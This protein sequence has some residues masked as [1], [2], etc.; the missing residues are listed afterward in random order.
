MGLGLVPA[1]GMADPEGMFRLF[2][3]PAAPPTVVRA[4]FGLLALTAVVLCV[5]AFSVRRLEI[6]YSTE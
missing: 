5:A 2:I 4:V 3:A 6:N 1:S